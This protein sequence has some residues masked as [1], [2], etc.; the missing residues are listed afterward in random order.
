MLT[1]IHAKN[2]SRSQSMQS[3]AYIHEASPVVAF[4]SSV[5]AVDS[6]VACHT[7][8]TAFIEVCYN[9]LARRSYKLFLIVSSQ[10]NKNNHQTNIF[11]S[12]KSNTY[13]WQ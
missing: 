11:D 9:T 8:G 6:Y 4:T 13:S 10:Q 3:H 12:T 5:Y 1:M 7:P 2:V